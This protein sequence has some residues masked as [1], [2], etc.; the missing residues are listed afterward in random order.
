MYDIIGIRAIN[1]R[2][3]FMKVWN[4]EYEFIILWIHKKLWNLALISLLSEFIYEFRGTKMPDGWLMITWITAIQSLCIP[5]PDANYPPNRSGYL[6]SILQSLPSE[7]KIMLIAASVTV[8][9]GRCISNP[10]IRSDF[11][12][13]YGS[14]HHDGGRFWSIY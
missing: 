1:I 4:E 13:D 12:T 3:E 2:Y 9:V 6:W 14:G 10:W 11:Q 5:G 8:P 7:S